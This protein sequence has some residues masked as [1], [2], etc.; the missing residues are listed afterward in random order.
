MTRLE[1]HSPLLGENINCKT[2]LGMLL[3]TNDFSTIEV[4]LLPVP[5]PQICK[6]A[7]KSPDEL[8]EESFRFSIMSRNII[9]I[10]NISKE[11]H[12]EATNIYVNAFSHT[13]LDN[14]MNAILKAYTSLAPVAVDPTSRNELRFTGEEVG[15]C[16]RWDVDSECIRILLAKENLV[17]PFSWKRIFCHT[18]V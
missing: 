1:V 16:G 17:T 3:K 4:G 2:D 13:V 11:L 12:R 10:D 14:L 6:A 9:S 15:I 8:L 18:S 5:V 7:D